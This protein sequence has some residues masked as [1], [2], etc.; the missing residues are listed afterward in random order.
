MG[1]GG[2][3]YVVEKGLAQGQRKKLKG[4]AFKAGNEGRPRRLK[5]APQHPASPSTGQTGGD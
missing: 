2:R 1:V 5:L 4:P 3:Q